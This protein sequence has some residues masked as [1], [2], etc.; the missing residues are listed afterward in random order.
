MNI[1]RRNPL[2][3]GRLIATCL[4]FVPALSAQQAHPAQ[5]EFAVL[6]TD[7]VAVST[8]E[9]AHLNCSIV[10]TEGAAKLNCES[11]TGNGEPLVYHVALLLG[12]D[13]VGYVVSCRVVLQGPGNG[14]KMDKLRAI[15]SRESGGGTPAIDKELEQHRQQRIAEAEGI[16]CPLSAGQ[17]V[18]GSVE[19]G[20]LNVFA[21]KETK[22]YRIETST[23]VGPIGKGSSPSESTTATT[24]PSVPS[25]GAQTNVKLDVH[26]EMS[27]GSNSGTGQLDQPSTPASTARVM[28]SSEPTG[29]DI[30]VDGNFMG[31]TPSLI[32]LPA[33][34]RTVRVEAKGQRPW[35]RTVNLTAGSKITLRASLD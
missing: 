35:S 34:S 7:R 14:S 19:G 11:Q 6:S 23:Y 22:T 30:Y 20:K 2:G 10:G 12:S 16:A 24:P 9:S 3:V 26:T 15:I 27:G 28:I 8:S 5:A 33:G 13:K 18:A 1:I 4:A 25:S 29:A 31:N 21:G 17:V 32:E